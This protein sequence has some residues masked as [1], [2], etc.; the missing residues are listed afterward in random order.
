MACNADRKILLLNQLLLGIWIFGGR[1]SG[2][3][4]GRGRCGLKSRRVK[5]VATLEAAEVNKPA[6]KAGLGKLTSPIP[7]PALFPGELERQGF[8]ILPIQASHLHHLLDLPLHHRD[9]FDRMIIAQ[10]RSENLTVV[11]GLFL[12]FDFCFVASHGRVLVT[13]GKKGLGR[14]MSAVSG[15]CECRISDT[16]P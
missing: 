4:A 9:P 12:S 2:P 15:A 5:A 10:A 3:P 1:A 16:I 13:G 11:G 6:R 14:K 7:I 8:D